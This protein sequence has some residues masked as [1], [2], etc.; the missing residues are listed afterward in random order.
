MQ[1]KNISH[2]DIKPQN[3]LV[4][5][6]E[7][8]YK[9]ADFGEAKVCLGMNRNTNKQTL[10]GTELYMSPLLF[11]ALRRKCFVGSVEHNAYKS[12]VYSFG[13]CVLFAASLC[14]EALYDIRELVSMGNVRNVVERYIGKR[15]S[16]KFV[17]LIMGML[18]V[19]EKM[20][21]DFIEMEKVF[22]NV[23]Y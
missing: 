10:R 6:D 14:Y 20:R 11:H 21:G 9:I 7:N 3:I 19:N 15:Y 1:R 16:G 17:E 13:Y 22:E 18:E 5:H 4:F 8:S 12:D 23:H 2:R